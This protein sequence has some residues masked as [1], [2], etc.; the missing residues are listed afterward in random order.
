MK[1]VFDSNTLTDFKKSIEGLD[2]LQ[3]Y[4]IIVDF[5]KNHN[6]LHSEINKFFCENTPRRLSLNDWNEAD[7]REFGHKMNDAKFVDW[8][9]TTYKDRNIL[10]IETDFWGSYRIVII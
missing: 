5:C 9:Q 10:F 1:Q 4:D 2:L 6:I 7:F 3:A 8:V